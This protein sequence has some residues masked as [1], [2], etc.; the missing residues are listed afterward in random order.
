MVH[1]SG[2]GQTKV[3]NFIENINVVKD[4]MFPVP[5][6]F[7]L[8]QGHSGTNWKEMYKVFNMGHRL[9]LYCQ[10]KV[11]KDIIAIS[12]A[13]DVDAQVIGFCEKAEKRGLQIKT[14]Q[15]NFLYE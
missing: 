4:N 2:G 6:L 3:L 1:C 8:I 11:A 7:R 10:A 14:D 9:E 13:F 15:G 12:S 5:P